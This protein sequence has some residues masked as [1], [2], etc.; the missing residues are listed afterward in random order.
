MPN[1]RRGH[2]KPGHSQISGRD[3]IDG[4]GGWGHGSEILVCGWLGLIKGS[5]RRFVKAAVFMIASSLSLPFAVIH[6]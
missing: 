5:L 1:R 3:A 6:S 2:G 4:V